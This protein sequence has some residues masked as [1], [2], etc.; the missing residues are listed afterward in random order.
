MFEHA[1]YFFRQN[2]Y[3]KIFLN[4]KGKVSKKITM[5]EDVWCSF[6]EG[7]KTEKTRQR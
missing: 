5:G 2:K 1:N 4:H 3:Q 6:M 7:K